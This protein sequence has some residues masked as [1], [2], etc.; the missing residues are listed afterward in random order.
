MEKRGARRRG[1]KKE[2]GCRG[3]S[4][5]RDG[6]R[7][8][9][10]IT[11]ESCGA[12]GK[13]RRGAGKRELGVVRGGRSAAMRDGEVDGRKIVGSLTY[14]II[15]RYRYRYITSKFRPMSL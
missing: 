5:G 1:A 15:I 14:F 7:L 8:E 4:R 11:R 3:R 13:S 2:R 9:G 12:L 6:G 10:G